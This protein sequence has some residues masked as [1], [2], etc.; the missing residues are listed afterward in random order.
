MINYLNVLKFLR[1][2]T[3]LE[4]DVLITDTESRFTFMGK[5]PV[6]GTD[7]PLIVSWTHAIPHEIIE[8]Q[9]EVDFRHLSHV[10]HCKIDHL[11]AHQKN[12]LD[13]AKC[14]NDAIHTKGFRHG[15]RCPN[16]VT[17]F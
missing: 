12:G 1:D 9:N 6:V 11:V 13:S 4:V 8:R 2:T 15:A 3:K 5:A 7:E 14:C 17:Q 16:L 10:A